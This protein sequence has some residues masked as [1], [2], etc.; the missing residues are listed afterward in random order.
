MKLANHPFRIIDEHAL[1]SVSGGRSYEM[2]TCAL[3][4]EGGTTTG[5][6][7][8]GG[9]IVYPIPEPAPGPIGGE[10]TQRLGEDGTSYLS[11][12]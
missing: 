6:G 12:R 7:E 11:E 4:E 1:D 5:C 8:D 2:S 9:G 3:G 10:Y